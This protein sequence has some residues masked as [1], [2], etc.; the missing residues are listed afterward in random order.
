M[1]RLFMIIGAAVLLAASPVLGQDFPARDL[2]FVTTTGI[3]GKTIDGTVF[4]LSLN[5]DYFV[6]PTLSVGPQG[7]LNSGSALMQSGIAGVARY[8]Y[9]MD[10]FH[11][12]PFAGVGAMY[13]DMRESSTWGWWIPV[14]MSVELP[15][16]DTVLNLTGTVNL[17][18][19]DLEIF[20]KDPKSYGLTIGVR[21]QP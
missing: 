7:T 16:Q 5:A 8:H 1:S 12:V 9:R 20:G 10:S 2:E 6:N 17:H 4:S 14:G 18:D 15:L 21:F 13:A 11:F 3:A 19:I